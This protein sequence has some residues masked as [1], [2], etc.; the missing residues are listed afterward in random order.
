M[1]YIRACCCAAPVKLK[2]SPDFPQARDPLLRI[3]QIKREHLDYLTG[4]FK[5]GTHS[6][7]PEDETGELCEIGDEIKRHQC[8][9]AASR[10]CSCFAGSITRSKDKPSPWIQACCNSREG[11]FAMLAG[12][13]MGC[14]AGQLALFC[15]GPTILVS[16]VSGVISG[17]ANCIG[18]YLTL[19][20]TVKRM[21]ALDRKQDLHKIFLSFYNSL[22]CHL[23]ATAEIEKRGGGKGEAR[24]IASALLGKKKV[25]LNAFYT[26]FSKEEEEKYN[27][28]GVFDQFFQA[29]SYI[30]SGEVSEITDHDLST[31]LTTLSSETEIST[32][33]LRLSETE[34]RLELLEQSLRQIQ[35]RPATEIAGAPTGMAKA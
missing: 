15:T 6:L 25:I 10:V 21:E 33:K 30:H 3:K 16:I 18:T 24:S 7:F 11:R 29:C 35:A 19:V 17:T 4:A 34:R 27:E 20:D 9:S 5:E 32:L 13:T 26:F 12:F 14:F 28:G 1:D 2:T 22:A 23:L 8:C 31:Y